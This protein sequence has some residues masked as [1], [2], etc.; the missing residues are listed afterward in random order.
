LITSAIAATEG[1]L[2]YYNFRDIPPILI[3]SS[4]LSVIASNYVSLKLS[5]PFG[6]IEKMIKDFNAN[7]KY[8]STTAEK[9][10]IE[11]FMNL[12]NFIIKSFRVQ[13]EKN[14]KEKEFAENARQV[15][16]DIRSPIVALEVVAADLGDINERKSQ[17]IKDV[18]KRVKEVADSLLAKY[19]EDHAS[20]ELISP[21]LESMVNECKLRVK[22]N[23]ITISLQVDAPSR[24]VYADVQKIAFKRVISNLINNALEATSKGGKIN[25][26]MSESGSDVKIEVRDNGCGI[27]SDIL[28]EIV[29]GGTS[30]GKEEGV[31]L[32]LSYAVN[33]IKSWGGDYNIHSKLGE[34]TIF[35][36][37]L[38]ISG[39]RDVDSQ[40]DLVFLDDI[41]A[42]TLAWEIRAEKVGREVATFNNAE[43]FTAFVKTCPHNINIYVDVDLGGNKK[44]Q[45]VAK[46]L[47]ELGYKN[48]YLTT[49]HDPSLFSDI[50]WIKGVIDKNPPF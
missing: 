27:P 40:L 35:E 11:E 5:K 23:L 26:R 1:S 20:S 44:G 15:A 43:A 47:Y 45:D 17:V 21:L 10:T 3:I 42:V 38:P 48:I 19:K 24:Y 4:I 50:D 32:G 22:K 46:V 30:Y 18:T 39:K 16:H 13:R 25:I 7:D 41:Q 37:T 6:E 2:L 9:S 33:C 29:K 34:G 31:G 8:C 28:P 14:R 12:R 36:F 49:G